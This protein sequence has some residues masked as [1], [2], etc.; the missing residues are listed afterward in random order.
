MRLP[1]TTFGDVVAPEEL[2]DRRTRIVSLVGALALA[3]AIFWSQAGQAQDVDE[4]VID[5]NRVHPDVFRTSIER[6]TLFRNRS[7]RQ[8]DVTFEG[9]AGQHHVSEDMGQL[10]VV[11]HR[12]GKHRYVVR[13]TDSE[14]EH[15]HGVVDVEPAS[16]REIQDGPGA[17]RRE[18]PVCNGVTV[19][20]LC[21]SP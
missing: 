6:K 4:I 3:I 16:V 14:V 7:D 9:Y 19:M 11:F 8:I 21:Y 13:F 15:L 18:P 1:T 12:P 17:A 20:Q 2:H 5:N 10:W